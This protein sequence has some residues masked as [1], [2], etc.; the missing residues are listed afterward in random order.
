MFY[1]KIILLIFSI[2]FSVDSISMEPRPSLDLDRTLFVY[3][4][5]EL[6]ALIEIERHSYEEKHNYYVHGEK[7]WK[8]ENMFVEFMRKGIPYSDII[9]KIAE[10]DS[11]Y[12]EAEILRIIPDA[13]INYKIFIGAVLIFCP[14]KNGILSD[15]FPSCLTNMTEEICF[16]ENNE[17]SREEKAHSVLIDTSIRYVKF[18]DARYVYAKYRGEKK[19]DGSSPVEIIC[20]RVQKIFPRF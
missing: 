6:K 16:L 4:P 18:E 15:C 3:V 20:L 10:W 17:P 7:I 13:A 14:F 9:H 11:E 2:T 1:I 12:S 19:D 8:S 5:E